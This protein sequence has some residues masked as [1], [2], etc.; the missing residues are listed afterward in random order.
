MADKQDEIN[1]PWWQKV[2]ALG[3]VVGI[4]VL[5]FIIA[6]VIFGK[7]SEQEA[8]DRTIKNCGG[9]RFSFETDCPDPSFE[10]DKAIEEINRKYPD[11][12][13]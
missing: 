12:S 2:L 9:S 8:Q 7:P 4:A 5:I 1:I 13:Y 3:V 11:D 6:T 10:A